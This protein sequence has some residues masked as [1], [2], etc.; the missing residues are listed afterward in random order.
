MR[1]LVFGIVCF[2]GLFAC[3]TKEQETKPQQQT[4]APTTIYGTLADVEG[5]LQQINPHMQE[6][7][8]IQLEVDKVV[9]STGKATGSNLAPVM[10]KN[11]PPLAAVEQA[12]REI[13]SPPL[14]AP[15]HAN[16]IKMVTLR[17]SAY[18]ATIRG[19]EAENSSGDLS[20]YTEAETQLKD[21]NKIIVQLNEEMAK[22]YQA[23]SE[24]QPLETA[25]P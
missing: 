6:I 20:L 24:S 7:G 10:K 25:A 9:G 8:R 16:I 4:S 17:L 21:A 15:F 11:R 12:L 2:V 5:Y 14:L 23:I 13:T 1:L 22:I 3:G 19:N 18:D